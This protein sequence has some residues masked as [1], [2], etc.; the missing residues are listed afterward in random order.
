MIG[1]TANVRYA[2]DF[3]KKKINQSLYDLSFLKFNPQ[4]KHKTTIIY[5]TRA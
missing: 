1:L 4:Q 3:Q 5:R 2:H